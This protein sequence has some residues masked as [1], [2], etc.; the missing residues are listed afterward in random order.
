ISSQNLVYT[1]V[2]CAGGFNAIFS[3]DNYNPCLNQIVTFNALNVSGATYAW[4]FGDGQQSGTSANPVAT[5]S[6]ATAGP[7]TVTLTATAGG[8]SVSSTQQVFATVCT[9]ISSNQGNWYFG[10][11]AGLNFSTGTPVATLNS[12][13][14]ATEGCITQSDAAG[15]LLFYSDSINVYDSNHALVNPS[16]PLNGNPSNTQAAISIPDPGNPKRYY[17]FTL[18]PAQGGHAKLWYTI[19]DCT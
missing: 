9:P 13:M 1:G 12:S 11:K 10:T 3:P 4:D 14:S 19:V 8:N 5:H 15:S 18:G 6:Y 17:L 16:T 2:Q 7:Y